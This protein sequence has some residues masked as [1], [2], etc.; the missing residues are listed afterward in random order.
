[1]L[2]SRRLL[3]FVLALTLFGVVA[4]P[5]ALAQETE[6]QPEQVPAYAT[7]ADLL[8]NEQTREQLIA[9]LRGLA[10]GAPGAETAAAEPAP[11]SLPRRIAGVTQSVAEGVVGQFERALAAVR[12]LGETDL[13]AGTDWSEVLG[14]TLQ[15]ALVIV[16]TFA[17]FLL[18]RRGVRGLFARASAWARG[19]G[20]ED[21]GSLIRRVAAILIAA[22]I[23]VAAILLAWVGG[24]AVALFVLG[25]AGAMRT[26]QS[27][28]LNAFVL[29]EVFK[30]LLRMLFA[31]RQDNLRLLPMQ[32]EDAAYW[33][34]RLA[35]LAGFVGY[36]LLLVVP[37]VNTVVSPAL[38]ALLAVAIML[39][40]FLY[41][42]VIILGN[43][44][45]VRTK[46]EALAG[47]VPSGF[48]GALL[49]L[50]AR[51][52]HLIAIAYFAAFAVLSVTRPGE[53]LPFMLRGTLWSLLAI[54]AGVFVER[55][56]TR[57]I[58]R[59]I[60][61][62]DETRLKYPQLEARLNSFMPAALKVMRAV[63]GVVVIALLFHAWGAFDLFAWSG[64]E[65]G[66][67]VIGTALSVA[68]IVVAATLIWIAI[69]SWIEQRLN[70][71]TG[72]GAPTA[73]EQTL[74]ALF[75]NAF[76]IVLVTMTLM[77]CLSEIGI[78]IGPLL[79]GAGVL[80][81]AIGFGAQKLVQDII[82]GV[83]I[84]LENAINT[85]DVI[86]VGG[87]SGTA[88]RLSIR[89]VGIRD[90]SGTF[91][92]VPFSSVD[93]VSNFMRD[94]A[95][96]VGVYGVGY[97]EDTDEVIE[98]LKA[99]FEELRTNPEHGPK[100][101]GDLEVHGVTALADSAVNIRVRIKTLP[102]AQWGVG[103]EYNRLVKRHLDAAGIEIPFPH[104]T[105]YF[106][107]DK[108][109]NAP[110]AR[111]TSVDGTNAPRLQRDTRTAESRKGDGDGR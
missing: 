66:R 9:E 77:I 85:G 63:I 50:L 78:D 62:P 70:P 97:R 89:S 26:Q 55:L 92:I 8:E 95:Y 69:A 44:R 28:F 33:N 14:T 58:G 71:N 34:A 24:Y 104:M 10:D 93:T 102:G 13:D 1:M 61:V 16:A 87:I 29:V 5:Q 86:T 56:L 41:A 60:R 35:R 48:G 3:S 73:R 49:G 47:R 75:R 17:L 83:F 64:S 43:R 88:E 74:L 84:Q 72:G 46:L 19:S 82:T 91:H 7:L 106:G 4:P 2:R 25:D 79:A 52:W 21:S 100:I 90:L 98:H 36:G 80:G 51:T 39:V 76:A 101:L 111:I 31:A 94:F 109:G 57:L 103:R 105:L 67:Q 99:A 32:A 81:L 65:I 59:E 38:G 53:A 22:V 15:L 18:L 68:F 6:S 12:D 107:E 37:I 45:L 23:D 54:G 27:L 20:E 108:N 96:H 30:A 42:L 11:E 40:A 110:P